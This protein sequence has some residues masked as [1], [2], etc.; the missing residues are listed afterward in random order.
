MKKLYLVDVSSM[1]FRAFFA[2]PPLTNGEGLPTNALYGFFNMSLKLLRDVHSD[3]VVYCFDRKEPSFRYEMYN[4][5]KANRAEMPEDLVPQ[6]P[7]IYELTDALGIPRLD[8]K[9]YE[10]DDVIGSMTRWGRENGLEVVIVS[11]DKDFAQ[12]VKPFVSMYDTMKDMRY[13]EEGVKQKWN[14]RASQMIDYLALVGDSSDNIPGVRGIGPKGAEKLLAQ[15]GSLEGVYDHIDEISGKSMKQKLLENRDMAF[16]SRQLVTIVQDLDLIA[17]PK[18]LRLKEIDKEKLQTLLEFL[19][20]KTFAKNLSEGKLLSAPAAKSKKAAEAESAPEVKAGEDLSDLPAFEESTV[21]LS[22][23][24]NLIE[25]YSEVW[26]LENERGLVLATAK[27]LLRVE[28]S[29]EEIGEVVREKR[30]NWKGFD[31]K[32][33]WHLMGLGEAQ[34]G[35]DAQ[36][37]AYVLNP[38]NTESLSEVYAAQTGQ[39]WPELM[40]FTDLFKVHMALERRLSQSLKADHG[41]KVYREI[42]LPL[43]PVL[44]EMERRGILVDTAELG[45]QEGLFNKDFLELEAAIHKAAGGP[46][47]VASPKQLGDILFEKL[48]LTKGKKTKTGYSTS[49]DVLEKLKAEH[50]VVNLVLEYRELAKLKSTYVDALPH[51]IDPRDGRVHSSFRQAATSTGRLSSVNPNLQ[52]IPIRTERGRRVRKAFIA[53]PG[54]LLL[55]VDYSQIELRVL[56]HMAGDEAL[57]KAFA[58][59]QDIHQATA[60]EVFGVKP[61][62]VTAD[63]RRT[64]KAVNFGI[65]YGQGVFGLSESLGI[66]RTEAGDIIE[67]Y[68]AKFSGVKAYMESVVEQAKSKGYVEMLSGRRRYIPEL[69]AANQNLRKFGERAA[70]NAPIQGTASDIV[71]MAMIKLHDEISLPMILQVHDELLFEGPPDDIE[72]NKK[73]VCSIMENTT[74]LDVPLKVNLATGSDWE[75]A[76]S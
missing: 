23:L 39:K 4:E 54:A 74:R 72:D 1:F 11:G 30:L 53:E 67:R 58:E 59:D 76:H 15:F 48:G 14:I 52:N 3:Y 17:D 75:A 70:I 66:S 21:S 10:A 31:L 6:M 68:F 18:D 62:D 49:S 28:A 57:K 41:E 65:A 29:P 25:P 46:F 45:E 63:L 32:R 9:G 55:S 71:K 50:S 12:L 5:Y 26:A 37:A 13:D 19:G 35:W 47:N 56:A 36:L 42:E 22:Q 7:Y 60:A 64:A 20:F 27:K 51:L 44:Y 69:K 38:K 34:A 16:L 61:K 24:S 43:M 8:K 33:S 40:S 73:L 2:I